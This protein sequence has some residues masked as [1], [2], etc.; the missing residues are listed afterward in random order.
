[1]DYSLDNLYLVVGEI[2]RE[3]ILNLGFSNSLKRDLLVN[4]K[5]GEFI[6][7]DGNKVPALL[8]RASHKS[9]FHRFNCLQCSEKECFDFAIADFK[10]RYRVID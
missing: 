9:S 7:C 10:K 4:T 2:V 8:I 1:M 3:M 5:W 6:T